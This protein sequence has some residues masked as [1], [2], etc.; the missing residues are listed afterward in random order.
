MHDFERGFRIGGV[1]IDWGTTLAE[2]AK[3]AGAQPANCKSIGFSRLSVPCPRAY[4][5]ETLSAEMTSYGLSRP[6]TALAYE[7]LPPAEGEVGPEVW[8]GP[9]S[10]MLGA[11]R[12]ESVEDVSDQPNPCDAVAYYARWEG[13]DFSVGLSIYGAL[14]EIPEG[15]S[16]GMLWLN[17]STERAAGPYLAEWRAACESLAVAARSAEPIRIFSLGVDQ[18]ARHSDGTEPT[19]NARLQR[20]ASLALTTPDIL[21]TPAPIAQRLSPRSFALWSNRVMKVHCL[22]TRW[23]TVI[24]DDGAPMKIGWWH[25]LPAKGPGQS[26]LHAGN[27]S[28]LDFTDSTSVPE[29]VNALKALPGVTVDRMES[30]DC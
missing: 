24:W 5:F 29:V 7:L 27:W 16:A 14:R 25:V 22:S 15:R 2:A 10:R 20:E 8:T 12:R 11:P 19:G 21:L 23:D 28:V 13:E 17:W 9:I 26:S 30:H 3:I 18:Y 1:L 4:G 6:V